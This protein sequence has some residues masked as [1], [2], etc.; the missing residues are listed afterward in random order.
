M[1]TLVDVVRFLQVKTRFDK[2]PKANCKD[3]SIHGGSIRLLCHRGLERD[4]S[5][6][7]LH[8]VTNWQPVPVGKDWSNVITPMAPS[9][10]KTQEQSS[11]ACTLCSFRTFVAGVPCRT[12]LQKSSLP[13]TIALQI[14]ISTSGLGG[15]ITISGC[16][17]LSQSLL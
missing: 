17:S 8:L 7:V 11:S 3:E 9:Y 13:A 14:D 1:A 16:Q 2:R 4:H 10:D 6:F 12:E 5:K 15:H